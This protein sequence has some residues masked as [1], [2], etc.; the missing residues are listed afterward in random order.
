MEWVPV[1]KV[2][3]LPPGQSL[4]VE[5]AGE[6]VALFNIE[7]TL[8]ACSEVCPHAGGP[9]HQGFVRGTQISCPW[10]GWTFDLNCAEQAPRDG[11]HRYAVKLEAGQV[12][13]RASPL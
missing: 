8:Y 1:A 4:V 10:H 7:G 12:Y 2:E 5:H 6:A 13:L 11:V 9:L 3:E